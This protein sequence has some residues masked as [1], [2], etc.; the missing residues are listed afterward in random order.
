MIAHL[1]YNLFDSEKQYW[2]WLCIVQCCF[3]HPI[4]CILDTIPSNIRLRL[5][6]YKTC[7][8]QLIFLIN[9]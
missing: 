1:I 6:A 5:Q 7:R 3:P 8:D 9:I 2:A 4:N